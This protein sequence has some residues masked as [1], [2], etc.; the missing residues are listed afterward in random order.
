[1]DKPVSGKCHSWHC[2]LATKYFRLLVVNEKAS[3]MVGWSAKRWLAMEVGC[4][5]D[6]VN[7]HKDQ[8]QGNS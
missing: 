6:N 5:T 3:V 7:A 8:E 2:N 1:M 4:Y